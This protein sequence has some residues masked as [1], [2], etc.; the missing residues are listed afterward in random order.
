MPGAERINGRVLVNPVHDGMAG[1]VIGIALGGREFVLPQSIAL[2]MS[3]DVFAL[4]DVAT[5]RC[6]RC[7]WWARGSASVSATNRQ[8]R[9][10]PPSKFWNGEELVTGWAWTNRDDW[11]GEFTVVEARPVA[12]ASG[13]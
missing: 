11:C 4:S 8:C 2:E 5:E 3:Q 9:R 1:G 12:N 7:K 13:C 6:V 10:Y